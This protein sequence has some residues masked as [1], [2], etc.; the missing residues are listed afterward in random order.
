[1]SSD[2]NGVKDG[3]GTPL[4]VR[5][6]KTMWSAWLSWCKWGLKSKRLCSNLHWLDSSDK[7]IIKP[8]GDWAFFKN[9]ITVPSHTPWFLFV[10]KTYS[11]W[12]WIFVSLYWFA[13]THHKPN[14]L[15]LQ[16]LTSRHVRMEWNENAKG[17]C[18]SNPR[19]FLLYYSTN[20]Y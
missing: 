6:W 16:L 5:T 10:A 13:S 4:C 17:L 8:D 1:M 19:F 9:P 20:D 7:L 11:W 3:T 12:S 2:L 15:N 14:L 18:I